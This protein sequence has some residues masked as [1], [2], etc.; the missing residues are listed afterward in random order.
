PGA[1]LR[2]IYEDMVADFEPQVRRL[3]DYVGV[4][5][6]PDCVNFHSTDRA[7]RTASSEQVRQPIY[8]SGTTQWLNFEPFLSPLKTLLEAELGEDR[9][10]D[11]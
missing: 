6:H 3:L 1:A 9:N 4:E 10:W 5:F 7:V 8:Q 11:R 2:V